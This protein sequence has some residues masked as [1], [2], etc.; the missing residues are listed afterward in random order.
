MFCDVK[1]E[2]Y[3]KLISMT[4]FNDDLMNVFRC[5]LSAVHVFETHLAHTA[6]LT[7]GADGTHVALVTRAERWGMKAGGVQCN[8]RVGSHVSCGLQVVARTKQGQGVGI[9]MNAQFKSNTLEQH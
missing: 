2:S 9:D 8:T 1:C 5:C 4:I 6:S 7:E 3:I